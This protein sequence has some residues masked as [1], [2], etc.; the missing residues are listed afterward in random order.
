MPQRK[1]DLFAYQD[2]L[3]GVTKDIHDA[4]AGMEVS[5]LWDKGKLRK[6]AGAHTVKVWNNL[7]SVEFRVDHDDLVERGDAY[8]GFLLL[9]SAQIKKKLGV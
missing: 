4:C 5:V 3:A 2:T 7:G 1:Q 8:K 9:L 6:V